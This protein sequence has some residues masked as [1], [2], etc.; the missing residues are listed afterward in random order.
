MPD[1]QNSLYRPGAF[2]RRRALI[3]AIAVVLFAC[4]AADADILLARVMELDRTTEYRL[5]T[6]EE[7]KAMQ[8]TFRAQKKA[9]TRAKSMAKKEWESA[10]ENGRFP[11][12]SVGAR[13]VYPV[14][15]FRDKETA[16]AARKT[17]AERITR[18]RKSTAA[19]LR[20]DEAAALVDKHLRALTG[21]SPDDANAE[22][23]KEPLYI[24]E[25]LALHNDARGLQKKPPVETHPKLCA[26]AQKYAEFMA[27][28]GRYGH[29]ENGEVQDRIAAEGY[30]GRAW[31]ENIAKGQLTP[32]DVVAG[33]LNSQGHRRNILGEW[34]HVGFGRA[35]DRR[36]TTYWVTVF[37]SP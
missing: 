13:S 31:G 7:L 21:E 8:D 2:P 36:G 32:R 24:R 25:L 34:H 5:I 30:K 12:L 11:S 27:E 15:T 35:Q 23:E 37:A 29:N 20:T 10:P 16:E 19:R 18:T 3:A 1:M 6:R 17:Y 22:E 28:T 14:R 26:A 4:R 33:W 9:F